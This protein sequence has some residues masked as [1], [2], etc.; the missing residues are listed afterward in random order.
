MLKKTALLS[1]KLTYEQIAELKNLETLL[2]II[3]INLI[4]Y[5]IS[6]LSHI[7]F[8]S[9]I[10]RKKN[11][12]VHLFPKTLLLIISFIILIINKFISIIFE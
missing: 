11:Y 10:I 4:S 12:L 5:T 7:F 8:F 3:N 2:K 6:K 1:E 9:R